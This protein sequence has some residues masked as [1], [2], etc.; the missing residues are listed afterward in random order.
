MF[1][2]IF[3]GVKIDSNFPRLSG[4]KIGQ[5]NMFLHEFS[6]NLHNKVKIK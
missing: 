2:F 4:T 5:N 6:L 1:F 3:S